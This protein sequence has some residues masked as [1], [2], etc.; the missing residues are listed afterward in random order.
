[1]GD[2]D[3]EF[4]FVL[5]S[6]GTSFESAVT[7]NASSLLDTLGNLWLSEDEMLSELVHIRHTFRCDCN[8]CHQYSDFLLNHVCRPALLFILRPSSLGTMRAAGGNQGLWRAD[9]GEGR[10]LSQPARHPFSP[11]AH[12]AHTT[13]EV[14]GGPGS[15]YARHI[16][17]PSAHQRPL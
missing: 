2:L 16:V 3:L 14:D 5:S 13:R 9:S 4:L 6:F 17:T 12:V 8:L 1:M 10:V 15:G 11:Q 7:Q